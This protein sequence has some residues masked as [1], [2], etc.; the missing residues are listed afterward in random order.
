MPWQGG[1]VQSLALVESEFRELGWT[2]A[3][4][5]GCFEPFG[6]IEAI[7]IN[8]DWNVIWRKGGQWLR[9]N[10]EWGWLWVVQG[11]NLIIITHFPGEIKQRG[12]ILIVVVKETEEVAWT[13]RLVEDGRLLI[14]SSIIRIETGTAAHSHGTGICTMIKTH[15][16]F[17]TPMIELAT[18]LAWAWSKTKEQKGISRTEHEETAQET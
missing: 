16:I 17:Y 8:V 5:I 15:C 11:L 4:G 6:G 9:S 2:E 18:K 13:V 1:A 14:E 12:V 10:T 3:I 7:E